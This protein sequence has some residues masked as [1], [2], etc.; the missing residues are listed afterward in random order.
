MMRWLASAPSSAVCPSAP[1][2]L[3]PLAS[4]TH[5]THTCPLPLPL[6]PSF[7]SPLTCGE[8]ICLVSR[9]SGD[10]T[11][12]AS[13]RPRPTPTAAAAG[14]ARATT[15]ATADP[16]FS[17]LRLRTSLT[18]RHSSADNE[19][20]RDTTSR[21]FTRLRKPMQST[22]L[23]DK[24]EGYGRA[25]QAQAAEPTDRSRSFIYRRRGKRRQW[26]KFGRLRRE[27]AI[28]VVVGRLSARRRRR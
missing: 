8:I 20:W 21:G 16:S 13:Q 5:H 28:T 14:R 18:S 12:A 10:A 26:T 1:A 15:L 11:P 19:R 6:S 27:G 3:L 9:P 22:N 4:L 2:S 17:H 7:H 25:A 23:L 24:L